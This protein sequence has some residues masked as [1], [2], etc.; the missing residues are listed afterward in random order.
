MIGLLLGRGCLVTE[1]GK[2]M[3]RVYVGIF[4]QHVASV[5]ARADAA[6]EMRRAWHGHHHVYLDDAPPESV[7]WSEDERP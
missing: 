3:L 2:P 6:E 7:I 1:D 5:V 4:D